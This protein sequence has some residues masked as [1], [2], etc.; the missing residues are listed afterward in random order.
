MSYKH[1]TL[2]TF[3]EFSL[4]YFGLFRTGGHRRPMNKSDSA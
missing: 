2:V 1:M 3:S 4:L